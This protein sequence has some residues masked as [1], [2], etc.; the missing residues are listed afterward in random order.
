[1]SEGALSLK[2]GSESVAAAET[3]L[4][5]ARQLRVSSQSPPVQCH[6]FS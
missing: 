5:Q 2:L 3:K 6:F 4:A 1:M